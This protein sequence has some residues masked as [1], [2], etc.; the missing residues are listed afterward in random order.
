[1]HVIL[2]HNIQC[3]PQAPFTRDAKF[4]W[5]HGVYNIVDRDIMLPDGMLQM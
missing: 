5:L 1:M 4:V 2:K 3:T